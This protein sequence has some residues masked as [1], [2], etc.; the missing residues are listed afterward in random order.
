MSAK[1]TRSFCQKLVWQKNSGGSYIPM[2][3]CGR[4]VLKTLQYDSVLSNNFSFFLNLIKTEAKFL[5]TESV[6]CPPCAVMIHQV[7]SQARACYVTQFTYKSSNSTDL[8]I[9]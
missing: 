9:R 6:K 5:R 3:K 1:S 2:S 4:N 7:Q 8:T